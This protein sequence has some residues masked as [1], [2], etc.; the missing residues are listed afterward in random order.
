MEQHITRV[1]EAREEAVGRGCDIA[2][3]WRWHRVRLSVLSTPIS[4]RH[5]RPKKC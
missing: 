4:N 3:R 1:G 2:R 5:S